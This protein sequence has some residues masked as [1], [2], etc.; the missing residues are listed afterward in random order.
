MQP[1]ETKQ[2]LVLERLRKAL[3]VQRAYLSGYEKPS[4]P[5]AYE[6]I[7]TLDDLFLRDLMEPERSVDTIDRHFR[8]ICTWGVNHALSRI[9]PRIPLSRPFRDFPSNATIQTQADDFVFNCATLGLSERFEGWLREGILVGE[10][11]LQPKPERVGNSDILV[12][13]GVAPSYS[14]EEIGL[15]GLRWVGEQTLK[16]D[17][18]LE[19]TLEERHRK[20]EPALERSVDLVAVGV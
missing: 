12:L 17:R 4:E 19:L 8:E 16:E 5:I 15:T 14:D 20:L 9:V 2:D 10:L 6:T 18:S 13:R 1:G 3:E 7:R 11:R